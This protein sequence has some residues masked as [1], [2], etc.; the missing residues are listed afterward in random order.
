MKNS[1][2]LAF[3]FVAACGGGSPR[4]APTPTPTPSDKECVAGGCSGT[5]CSDEEGVMTTCEWRAEYACYKEA[6]CTR[7]P[8]GACG[9]TKTE[10]L[11]SCLASPPV[12]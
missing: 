9:W 10:M 4:P 7:Q 1:I 6:E 11:T 3:M 5:V 2:W 8:D 12:E